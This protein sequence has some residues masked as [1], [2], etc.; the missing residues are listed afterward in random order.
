MAPMLG[1]GGMIERVTLSRT[2]Y[3]RSPQRFEAGTPP[4]AGAVGLGAAVDWQEHQDW[5]ALAQ[6]DLR[7]TGRIL[8][9]L[10]RIKGTRVIGPAGLQG[11][12]GIVSFALDGAHPHDV[13]QLLDQRGVACRGGHHCTQPLHE[14]LGLSGSTRASLGPYSDDA[15]VDALLEGVAEAGR[16]FQ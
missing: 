10:A 15:A 1:G 6:E 11:R 4:I 14:R 8:D 3:A 5:A 2:T 13:C 9:G 16:L 7:L 12:I